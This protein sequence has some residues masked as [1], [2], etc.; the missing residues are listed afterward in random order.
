[1]NIEFNILSMYITTIIECLIEATKFGGR[2][3]Y[4]ITRNCPK[5]EKINGKT[6]EL[7]TRMNLCIA[8]LYCMDQLKK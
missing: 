4:W 3:G 7:D 8:I 1:M 2:F 5:H 6:V